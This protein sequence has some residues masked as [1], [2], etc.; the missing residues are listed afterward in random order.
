MILGTL[1]NLC[2]DFFNI[3]FG[4]I[5]IPVL[6]PAFF[7]KINKLLDYIFSGS[8]AILWFLFSPDIFKSVVTVFMSLLAIDISLRISKLIFKFNPTSWIKGKFGF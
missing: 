5:K 7:E 2:L 8:T 3:V 4:W 6:I 1:F